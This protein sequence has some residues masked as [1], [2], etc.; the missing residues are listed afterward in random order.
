MSRV[1][2]LRQGAMYNDREWVHCETFF[3]KKFD[4]IFFLAGAPEHII[5]VPTNYDACG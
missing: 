2:V 4:L 1:Y 5:T 3:G